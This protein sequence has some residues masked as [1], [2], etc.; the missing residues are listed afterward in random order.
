MRSLIALGV[1]SAVVCSTAAPAQAVDTEAAGGT[2]ISYKH[3]GQF[4][5]YTQLGAGYRALFPY[6]SE[7][8]GEAG[9]SVCTGFTPLWIELGVSYGISNSVEILTD[10]RF[11]LGSDFKPDTVFSGAP[12]VFAFAPGF[13]FY[14]NDV[15][16]LKWFSTLQASFDFT[17]YST[18]QVSASV[19]V[20]VRNVNGILVDLHRTFGVYGH[21]GE[22][23][24]FVRWLRFE[25]D[26]GIGMQVRFP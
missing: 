21:F 23:V 14:I 16:S 10:F 19:D 11:G 24:S 2:S 18:S 25:M 8:C 17:D 9:K 6:H 12:H 4:G 13:K 15:G 5:I 7:F 20:G 26:A 3:Q 1:V 22:T